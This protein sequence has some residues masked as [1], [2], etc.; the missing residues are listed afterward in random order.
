[1]NCFRVLQTDKSTQYTCLR[2]TNFISNLYLE[3][4][5]ITYTHICNSHDKWIKFAVEKLSVAWIIATLSRYI[6]WFL[7]FGNFVILLFWVTY[8]FVIIFVHRT[9]VKNTLVD[10]KTAS[11]TLL[12]FKANYNEN[13]N[14]NT[15]PHRNTVLPHGSVICNYL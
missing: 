1:M 15:A 2:K 4:Q 11:K 12:F 8:K 6:L 9:R 10:N 13:K 7:L 5:T 3:M 14:W